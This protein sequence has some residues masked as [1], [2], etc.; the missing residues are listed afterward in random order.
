MRA[1]TAGVQP[2]RSVSWGETALIGFAGIIS[3]N[4]QLGGQPAIYLWLLAFPTTSLRVP[5][6]LL[7]FSAGTLFQ[8]GQSTPTSGAARKLLVTQKAGHRGAQDTSAAVILGEER[9]GKLG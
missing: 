3:K 7:W 2:V 1:G 5:V 9:Q 4:T 6:C 8:G